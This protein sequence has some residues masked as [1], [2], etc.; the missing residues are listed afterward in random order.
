M[1]RTGR[2]LLV[3]LW[4]AWSAGLA[5][6]QADDAGLQFFE[7]RIRPMLSEHCYKC[8]SARAEKLKGKL[9]LDSRD[10]LLKG[11]E[12]GLV[13]IPGHPEKSRLI[14]AV[15]YQ[16]PD[17]QM[18]PKTRLSAQQVEDLSRWVKLGAPWPADNAQTSATTTRPVDVMQRLAGHW[19]WQPVHP[20]KPPAVKNQQWARDPIDRF[21]LAKLD[22]NG[23]EPAPPADPRS[24]LRRVYFSLTGLPP[25]REDVEAFLAE[26][27]PHQA[28]ADVVDTLLA[29][30]RFGEHWARHWMDL[31]RYSDTLG[32]EADMPVPNAWRYRDY[33]IRAFNADVPYNRLIVEHIAG[34]LL[35]HPRRDPA[36]NLNESVIGTGFFW[37]AEGKRSP[38]DLRLAQADTFDNRLDV[39]AKTFLGVTLACA[40]CHDHKFD[41]IAQ[42]DYYA[43]YGYLK[44]S[45]YTQAALNRDPLDA[46]AARLASLRARIRV[47]AADCLS[48]RAATLARY[49]TA[50]T[51]LVAQLNAGPPATDIIATTATSANL[52]PARLARW[53]TAIARTSPDPAHPLYAWSRIAGLGPSLSAHAIAMRWR[54]LKRPAAS[55]SRPA[56]DIELT[57]FAASGFK[58][59]F[60]ED[61]A[62]GP[63]PLLPGDFLMG[64]DAVRPVA[65]FVRGGT[66]AHSGYLSRR[67]QGTLRSPT[68]TIDRRF[69]HILAAGRAS[70]INVIIDHFVMIQ[71]PLYGSLRRIVNDES[72]K[73]ITYDLGLWQGRQAYV[74]FA[75]TTTPDL[76]DM[77]PPDGCGPQGYLAVSRM[78]LSARGAAPPPSPPAPVL[79]LLGDDPPESLASLAGRYQ[80]AAIES[81]ISFGQG[82]LSEAPDAQA[83]ATLL[84]WFV[85]HGLLDGAAAAQLLDQLFGQ[86]HQV[87]SQLPDPI[88]V[89]AMTEGLPEDEYI[90]LRGN[91][92]TAGPLAPRRA[93]RLLDNQIP[94]PA[95]THGSGRLELARQI[96]DPANPLVARVF[97]NRVWHHLFGRG[98]VPSVDNFGALG[99]RPSHP[100]L[101]DYL[102]DRF[103]KEGW[104]TKKLI[105]ELVLSNTFGQSSTPP[106]NSSADPNNRLLG[107][108]PVR[109]LEA[110]AIRDQILAVSGRLDRDKMFGPGVEVHLTPFMENGY[111]SDYGHPKSSGPLDGQGRR[112]VYLT[113]RRN[114]LNPMLVAFD[115][116]PPLNTAGRRSVSNVP[117]QALILMND[118]FVLEQAR[119]WAGRILQRPGLDTAGR[120][121]RMYLEA[122]SRPPSPG[123]LA[124]ALRFLDHHGD[125]LNVAPQ[126]R[127]ND[128]RLWADFA[129]VLFNVKEFI[130]LN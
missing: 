41:P 58:G 45:R 123:E 78:L 26:P 72:P 56:D 105:R 49:L 113:I 111:T 101:L 36:T 15:S 75:D 91:P 93:P 46:Q 109:R 25:T 44:S 108:M 107:H 127:G 61:Q 30:P 57:D 77:R 118:P 124:V 35:T 99:D 89:P 76:H 48:Q 122:F 22:A 112:S 32:N 94:S 2:F 7:T 39:M 90:F 62:F 68:F 80:Q 34:D 100:E 128:P 14:E 65:T 23:L 114:F 125:E 106:P 130:F 17:L 88:R 126:H 92:K 81:L 69:L 82:K 19:A 53:L 29:S 103:V 98:I 115:A 40:R 129:H 86:F 110:E 20:T 9:L 121:R 97:V 96:A 83:R 64:A 4:A 8:H 71:D 5:R 67:L 85:E 79:A 13:V 38:V 47:A 12:E 55:P 102:A 117:A 21:I 3:A 74:E 84:A 119:L 18:P 37:F 42:A 51:G 33:L 59:W 87:E 95:P 70:R 63:A 54:D 31:V 6:G 73:W 27:E 16:N 104:S 50:T 120:V 66:W 43:L 1:G 10:G 11:G 116:P 28:L 24:L 60:V 52:E